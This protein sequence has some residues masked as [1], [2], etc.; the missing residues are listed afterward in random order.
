MRTSLRLCFLS[1]N[2]R[3]T[4]NTR[5]IAEARPGCW[6]CWSPLA[7]LITDAHLHGCDQ[8]VNLCWICHRVYDHNLIT[9]EEIF[10]ACGRFHADP[11]PG[12]RIDELH[13]GWAAQLAAEPSLWD[14]RMHLDKEYRRDVAMKRREIEQRRVGALDLFGNQPPLVWVSVFD[15]RMYSCDLPR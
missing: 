12:P 8:K 1:E 13:R 7:Q 11:P 3:R 2:G 14:T 15:W 10:E 6:Y 4:L 9:T 5:T